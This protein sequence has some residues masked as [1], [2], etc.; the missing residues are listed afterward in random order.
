M[1]ISLEFS[2]NIW[3]N[4]GAVRF[5]NQ[6]IFRL[7]SM[8]SYTLPN[9]CRKSRFSVRR[10][11]F[12]LVELLVVITIIGILMGMV[13]PAVNGARE[14]ARE[15]ICTNNLTQLSRATLSHVSSQGYYPS[16][17]WG[18]YWVGEP[19]CGYGSQQPGGWFFNV[20]DYLD[21]GNTRNAGLGLNGG[22]RTAA[23]VERMSNPVPIINCP[24]R[25]K[26]NVYP[27]LSTAQYITQAN[28]QSFVGLSGQNT[29]PTQKFKVSE[30]I[31]LDYA[32]NAGTSGNDING[33][34][35][36][37]GNVMVNAQQFIYKS[38]LPIGRYSMETPGWDSEELGKDENGSTITN[39]NLKGMNGVTFLASEVTPDM[40][41]DGMQNTYL[42]GEKFL[43]SNYYIN[44]GSSNSD[45]ESA[46]DGADNDN[47]RMGRYNCT[48]QRD[49][50]ADDR[51]IFLNNFGGPHAS[52]S[53]MSFCDGSVRK[54]N[55]DIDPYIHQYFANRRDSH[56]IE[57]WSKV[58]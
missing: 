57:D 52:G 5:C 42:I 19:D 51:N 20:L 48:P 18:Y 26:R 50:A 28:D 16:G 14:T 46:Y 40:V 23:L 29:K 45:N 43:N 13:L 35:L 31:K 24:T 47:Q 41:E 4:K 9:V 32:V 55:Y 17:G 15:L 22:D 8:N 11:A 56:K 34:D 21:Q 6:N 38:N 54:I 53:R 1:R 49:K 27:A 3:Y 37:G 36:G 39:K 2:T 10:T 33:N 44:P 25:R 30:C 58:Q 7:I 12:T